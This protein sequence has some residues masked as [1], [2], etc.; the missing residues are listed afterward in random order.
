[1]SL[2]PAGKKRHVNSWVAFHGGNRICFGKTLA[3]AQVKILASYLCQKFDF[4]FEDERYKTE[5]PMAQ[6]DMSS[7]PAI[8]VKL[9][10]NKE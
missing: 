6:I 10:A 7:S 2:T 8:W 9:T 4:E 5:M 3:E 1:M